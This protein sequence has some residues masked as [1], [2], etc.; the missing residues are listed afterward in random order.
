MVKKAINIRFPLQDDAVNNFLFERTLT[1]KDAIKSNLL[2]LLLTNVGERYYLPDY[3]LNLY[4][5][6]FEPKD[7]EL[8]NQVIEEIKRRVSI[9]IP[10]VTINTI[11]IIE[12]D[13]N[14]RDSDNKLEINIGFTYSQN[15]FSESDNIT[16]KI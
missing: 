5:Y 1:T 3:G 10:E 4:K 2:L 6:L 7:G 9:Y 8:Q 13:P 14:D 12:N 11:N 16:I 15:T